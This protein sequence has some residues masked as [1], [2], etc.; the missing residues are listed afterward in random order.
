MKGILPMTFKGLSLRA[1]VP[2]AMFLIASSTVNAAVLSIDFTASSNVASLILTGTNNVGGWFDVTG[3]NGTWNGSAVSGP[4]LTTVDGPPSNRFYFSP[5]D[6]PL[7][8]VDHGFGFDTV[9]GYSVNLYAYNYTSFGSGYASSFDN[10]SNA[11]S[12]GAS[13]TVV[14]PEPASAVLVIAGLAV[15]TAFRRR[16]G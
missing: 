7:N 12:G 9:S 14:T 6:A 10:G 2:A 1:L 8:I 13:V 11:G 16:R 5:S 3:V 4:T 15:T